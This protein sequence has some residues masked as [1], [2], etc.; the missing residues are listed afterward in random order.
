M[1][2][3]IVIPV[4]NVESYL[5][6][7]LD[8]I[9]QQTYKELSV[10]LVDDGSTDS[11]GDICDNY[12]EKFEFISTY[13]KKNGGLISAWKYGLEKVTTEF[14]SFIDPDDW[15][16]ES[17]YEVLVKKQI[18]SSADIVSSRVVMDYGDVQNEVVY[19][20][21]NGLYSKQKISEIESILLT[22]GG[23]MDRA[24]PIT[25]WAKLIKKE[26][27]IQNL[28]YLDE[29]VT[30]GEDLNII[31]P[32]ILDADSIYICNDESATYHYRV[33]VDSMQH[34]YDKNKLYSV[35]K[36][37]NSLIEVCAS[38]NKQYLE[39]QV[40]MDY[41]C[42]CVQCYKNEL[43]EKNYRTAMLNLKM[44]TDTVLFSKGY[45]LVKKNHFGLLNRLIVSSL[46]NNIGVFSELVYYLLIYLNRIKH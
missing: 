3:S 7:C 31:F 8:S 18:E 2:L 12:S 1:K 36:V 37:Y 21:P 45:L 26:L 39:E 22:H 43:N 19:A 23:F 33:R 42:A 16:N 13:H 20:I 10:I 28:K 14:V 4:Y 25:R 27:V 40:L 35:N 6:Q 11:S 29:K 41:I 46:K 38:K 17:Y 24:L 5:V 30:Y 44:L 9:I 15:I 34:A 32:I